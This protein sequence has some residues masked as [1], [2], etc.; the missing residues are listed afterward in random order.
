MHTDIRLEGDLTI[1]Q[2][3]D[4]R[5]RLLQ[6]LDEHDGLDV[7]LADITE[8]DTAGLQVLMAAKLSARERNKTLRYSGHSAAILSLIE[9][10]ELAQWLGDPLVLPPA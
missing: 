9:L 4:V 7:H 3:Q 6:A 8:A 1:Y 10:Y 2:A 5:D